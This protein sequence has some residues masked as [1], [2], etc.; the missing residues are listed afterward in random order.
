[1]RDRAQRGLSKS[2]LL[3]LPS[4][5]GNLVV[6]VQNLELTMRPIEHGR[7]GVLVGYSEDEMPV[8][9]L[10]EGRIDTIEFWMQQ[11][12]VKQLQSQML[13]AVS[14]DL[15]NSIEEPTPS[16]G[17][18]LPK[19]SIFSRKPA[20]AAERPRGNRIVKPSARVE[21]L[22]EEAYF[23]SE[24]E[25]GLYETHRSKCVSLTVDVR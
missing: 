12:A 23:R 25:F 10:L 6:C 3:L 15:P 18:V 22:F 4:D 9:I 20:K 1:M 19:T 8:I 2:T 14:N 17:A 21:A 16:P 5:Q 11:E 13:T 24:N 7:H